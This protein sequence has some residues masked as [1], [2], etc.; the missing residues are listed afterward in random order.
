MEGNTRALT[1][2]YLSSSIRKCSPHTHSFSLEA[3]ACDLVT[4]SRG[5]D[6]TD[7]ASKWSTGMGAGALSAP[8]RLEGAAGSEPQSVLSR[9][10]GPGFPEL[11]VFQK[12]LHITVFKCQIILLMLCQSKHTCEAKQ[13]TGYHFVTL[14]TTH[15]HH[16]LLLPSSVKPKSG[17]LVKLARELYILG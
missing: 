4:S 3:P 5:P 9:A 7:K 1:I 14:A 11:P 10:A 6:Q 13:S 17:Y 8:P 2:V 15:S 16:L 12:M